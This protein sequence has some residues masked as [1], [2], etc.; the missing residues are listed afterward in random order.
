METAR[1]ARAQLPWDWR[2]AIASMSIEENR[3]GV[4]GPIAGGTPGGA[5]CPQRAGIERTSC[6]VDGTVRGHTSEE[7]LRQG[8]HQL[9]EPV[10]SCKVTCS[11]IAWRSTTT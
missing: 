9:L 1:T 8:A 10:T 4:E 6:L 7:L 5:P 11:T 3:T 2:I